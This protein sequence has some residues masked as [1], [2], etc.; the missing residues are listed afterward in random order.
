MNQWRTVLVTSLGMVCLL[1][2]L[3]LTG[4]WPA[5]AA[6]YAAFAGGI[7]FCVGAVAAKAYGQHKANAGKPEEAKP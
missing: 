3:A 2:G 6:S 5:T 4:H 1:A 7:G